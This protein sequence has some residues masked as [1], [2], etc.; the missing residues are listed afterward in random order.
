MRKSL[1]RLVALL[2]MPALIADPATAAGRR[3]SCDPI[4]PFASLS[5][6]KLF[7]ESALAMI[8]TWWRRTPQKSA[9]AQYRAAASLYA[10]TPHAMVLFAAVIYV[11]ISH[12]V[13]FHG[14]DN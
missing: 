8:P 9:F 12:L 3:G 14:L 13:R 7:T 10:R 5:A 1:L 11:S 6:S 4:R 2:I